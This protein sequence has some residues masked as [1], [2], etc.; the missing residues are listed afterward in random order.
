M[1]VQ[2]ADSI[3]RNQ[4][5]LVLGPVLDLLLLTMSIARRSRIHCLIA[6]APFL[7]ATSVMA[8]DAKR[9]EVMTLDKVSV[10]IKSS[11]AADVRS[12][13]NTVISSQLSAR[14]INIPVRVGQTVSK[15]ELL[16]ELDC[17]DYRA[18]LSQSQAQYRAQKARRRLAEHQLKRAQSLAS[19]Q[20]VSADLLD[21]RQA[22][23]DIVKAEADGGLSLITLAKTQ[24]ARCRIMNPFD[25]AVTDRQ[26]D[27]AE[28]AAPGTPLLTIT[29]L[30]DAEISAE[31]SATEQASLTSSTQ[32]LFKTRNKSYPTELLRI[33]PVI[34]RRTR[35]QQVR[36]KF[37]SETAAIG[38]S[39]R[40][41]WQSSKTGVPAGLL[42]QRQGQLGVF[43][44]VGDRAHFHP[45][46][47]ALEGRPANVELP[48][49]TQLVVRGQQQLND[50]DLIKMMR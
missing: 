31:I 27:V 1:R 8:A 44:V 9:V 47:K 3:N 35:T 42:V 30:H 17:T 28:L 45:L 40:L 36:L 22:E 10:T 11:V 48:D 14:I 13:Q 12:L 49:T 32:L 2:R 38:S 43:L 6:A 41:H 5:I 24:V 29:G 7:L 50:N 18:R 34:D 4:I 46:P 19:K 33:S 25:A 20:H 37:S 21:Q 16:A 23:L 15:G 26:A 39:G